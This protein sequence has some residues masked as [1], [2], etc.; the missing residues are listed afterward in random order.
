MASRVI[1]SSFT[2]SH[3]LSLHRRVASP[4]VLHPHSVLCPNPK[5]FSPI[6][7]MI[8]TPLLVGVHIFSHKLHPRNEKNMKMVLNVWENQGK[9]NEYIIWPR[10]GSLDACCGSTV[11]AAGIPWKVF[12]LW[13]ILTW[14]R[15]RGL[16]HRCSS[17]EK[18]WATNKTSF[19]NGFW[20]SPWT[21]RSRQQHAS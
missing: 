10:H 1:R 9:I 13:M 8:Y 7:Q 6:H 16:W 14:L 4:A 12:T 20:L 18:R 5:K 21:P 3:F 2:N 19:R 11:T 17:Y 15:L